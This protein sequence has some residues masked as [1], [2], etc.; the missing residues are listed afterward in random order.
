MKTWLTYLAAVALALAATL[1]MGQN[2]TFSTITTDVM[3]FFEQIGMCI[4]FL[5]VA[6]SFTSGIASI[7]KDDKLKKVIGTTILWALVS[8]IVTS[9]VGVAV[10]KFLPTKFPVTSSTGSDASFIASYPIDTSTLGS[11]FSNP[12]SLLTFSFLPAIMLV[13]FIVG[14]FMKPNV[15]VI[16]PAYVVM[17]SFSELMFR[18]SRAFTLISY[19]FVFFAASSFFSTLWQEGSIFVAGRFL[20]ML[21]ASCLVAILGILPLLFAIFTRFKTNPYQII[22]RNVASLAVGLFTGDIILSVVLNEPM[23]RHN[24][25]CQKRIGATT[26]PTFAL[27]GRGGS[28]MLSTLCCL[29]LIYAVDAASATPLV[30]VLVALACALT[31]FCSSL[32]L[33]Y[34]VF[35]VT[36]LSFRLLGINLY[37]VEVS[38]ISLLPL[39]NGM[40]VMVDNLI[41]SMGCV[42]VTQNLGVRVPTPYREIL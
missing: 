2:A 1:L 14:Y 29:S 22:Y 5:L 42:Y 6:C 24:L 20:V 19:F 32:H 31:S 11:M 25:G 27:I 21:V 39:L 4:L 36:V 15:E 18:L 33:G 3:V 40:G 23:S 9:F 13:C 35:L 10:F 7:R 37:G 28:A 38:L 16:R 30:M 8:T 26:I 12:M 34:E 41:A 17:N